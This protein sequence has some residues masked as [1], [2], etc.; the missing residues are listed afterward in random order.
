MNRRITYIGTLFYHDGIQVFE[1]RDSIG[2]SY[3]G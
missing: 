2:G 1:G 3:V